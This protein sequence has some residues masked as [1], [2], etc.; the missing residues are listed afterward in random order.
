[1]IQNVGRELYHNPMEIGLKENSKMV[2]SMVRLFTV[3]GMEEQKCE[4]IK[5]GGSSMIGEISFKDRMDIIIINKKIN[6]N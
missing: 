5:M 3:L 2:I 4:C 6:I 1:M